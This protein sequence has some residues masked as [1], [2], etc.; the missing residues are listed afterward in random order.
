MFIP[1]YG[2]TSAV[3]SRAAVRAPLPASQHAYIV[4][5]RAILPTFRGLLVPLG[6]PICTQSTPVTF[7]PRA[8]AVIPRGVCNDEPLIYVQYIEEA[9][10]EDWKLNT[11]GEQ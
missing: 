4:R 1:M 10:T 11:E 6:T 9:S 8:L 5:R 2:Y 7:A 3:E